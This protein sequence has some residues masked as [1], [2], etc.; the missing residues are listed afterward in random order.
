MYCKTV[1]KNLLRAQKKHNFLLGAPFR[2]LTTILATPHD[3]HYYANAQ[4]VP[5]HAY[6][7]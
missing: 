3:V 6:R 4:D 2:M 7:R 5:F 1:K